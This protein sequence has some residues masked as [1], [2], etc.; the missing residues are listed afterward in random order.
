MIPVSHQDQPP[1]KCRKATLRT[2]PK[3]QAPDIPLL[4]I[5]QSIEPPTATC[6][7]GTAWPTTH[8]APVMLSMQSFKPVPIHTQTSYPASTYIPEQMHPSYTPE[9]MHPTP[10]RMPTDSPHRH[11]VDPYCQLPTRSFPTYFL[12]PHSNIT[13]ATTPSMLIRYISKPLP[14]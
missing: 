10:A 12:S 6:P 1:T 13:T 4:E 14:T 2:S 11:M 3:R 5:L 8:G 9:Q 7:V